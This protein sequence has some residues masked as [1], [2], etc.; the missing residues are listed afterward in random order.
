MSTCEIC[1]TVTICPA[2][3][4]R[5]GGK[6]RTEAKARTARENAR[7]RFRK[8]YKHLQLENRPNPFGIPYS[9]TDRDRERDAVEAAGG[10]VGE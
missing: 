8:N 2:C 3:M 4:G 10:T 7:K 9:Q 6:A 1:G 5:R